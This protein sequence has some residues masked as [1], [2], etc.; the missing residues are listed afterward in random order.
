MTRT[1]FM[2]RK[3]FLAASIAVL[4]ASTASAATITYTLD[5]IG[6]APGSFS[7][8]G[9]CST[10]DNAGI[11]IFGVPL[12]G[13]VLTLDNAAPSMQFGQKGAFSGGAGFNQVRSADSAAPI[14]NPTI[15]GGQDF[16]NAGAPNN[17]VFGI[18]Q[19]AGSFTSDGWTTLFAG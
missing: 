18:G 4:L 2:I 14:D 10:G 11:A 8:Y 17:L 13:H 19:T 3:G 15:A 7:L 16:T 1:T 5:L 6:G 9:K 12:T